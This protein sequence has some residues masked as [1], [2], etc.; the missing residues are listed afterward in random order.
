MNN[1]NE[2]FLKEL[3]NL[4]WKFI[5]IADELTN[6]FQY[7]VRFIG[8]RKVT[9]DYISVNFLYQY[10]YPVSDR[11]QQINIPLNDLEN[12]DKIVAEI[13]NNEPI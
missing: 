2:D 5:K 3:N 7:N 1:M 11:I 6:K 12:I 13:Y 8:I 10:G 4:I 9:S